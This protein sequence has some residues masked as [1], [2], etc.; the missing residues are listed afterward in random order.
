VNFSI[1]GVV[2]IAMISNGLEQRTAACAW[3]S[4]DD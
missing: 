4:K 2:F 1:N 3:A